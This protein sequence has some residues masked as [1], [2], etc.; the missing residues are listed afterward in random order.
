MHFTDSVYELGDL[1]NEIIAHYT[2][3]SQPYLRDLFA[4]QTGYTTPKVDV[5]G[6]VFNR[7]GAL[8]L[9][10]EKQDQG[11]W[12]L[13]GGWADV[14]DTPAQA[15]VREVHEEAGYHTRVAKVLAVYDRETQGHPPYLFSAYKLFFRCELLDT[16][17]DS[18]SH[19][20]ETS[21][22]SFF[23]EADCRSPNYRSDGCCPPSC[24]A[25]SNITV[26]LSCQPT[27]IER[28]VAF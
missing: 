20:H 17:P 7:D 5:R 11:R 12:T 24:C 2:E 13:P 14:G 16:Q 1:A 23:H 28:M 8:L 3:A 10:R 26:S 18:V 4:T 6:V 25:S 22:A 21:D 19:T 15:V 9:V 27:S